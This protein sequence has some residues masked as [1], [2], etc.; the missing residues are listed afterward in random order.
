[1]GLGRIRN[2]LITLLLAF[3]VIKLAWV[4]VEPM[5]APVGI[6]LV[7]I[8]LLMMLYRFVFRG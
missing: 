1:M 6:A 7:V 2:T 3:V 5:V 4:T 8:F